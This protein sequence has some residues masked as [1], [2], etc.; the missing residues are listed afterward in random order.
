MK[1]NYPSAEYFNFRSSSNYH[2]ST[3]LQTYKGG[4]IGTVYQSPNI[5]IYRVNSIENDKVLAASNVFKFET[6]CQLDS[7]EFEIASPFIVE[8]I[9]YSHDEIPTL[10]LPEIKSKLGICLVNKVELLDDQQE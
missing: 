10:E 5:N 3:C 4:Y 7:V 6:S 9:N 2:C 8:P 1:E